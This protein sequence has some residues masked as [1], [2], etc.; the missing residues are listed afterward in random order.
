[1]RVQAYISYHFTKRALLGSVGLEIPPVPHRGTGHLEE[2]EPPW[3]CPSRTSQSHLQRLSQQPESAGLD[4]EDIRNK[5]KVLTLLP[6]RG[7]GDEQEHT[8][9]L[10]DSQRVYVT[11]SRLSTK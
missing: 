1:M 11:M 7:Y 9:G 6:P 4:P 2:E 8:Q 5:Q 10:S 3:P